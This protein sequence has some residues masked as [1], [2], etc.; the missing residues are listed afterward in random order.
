MNIS[1]TEEV[2][3]RA[4]RRAKVLCELGADLP[5]PTLT[6]SFHLFIDIQIYIYASYNRYPPGNLPRVRY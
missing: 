6:L 3:E 4:E 5:Q 1:M 2:V